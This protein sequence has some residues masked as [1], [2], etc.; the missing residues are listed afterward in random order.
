MNLIKYRDPKEKDYLYFWVGEHNRVVYSPFF[1]T[2]EGAKQWMDEICAD[3][4]LINITKVDKDNP[5]RIDLD[6]G[7]VND[8]L[9]EVSAQPGSN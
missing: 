8:S 4:G 6:D 7:E 1:S 9:I 3:L 5:I 2:E